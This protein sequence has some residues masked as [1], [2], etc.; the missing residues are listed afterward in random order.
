[1]ESELTRRRFV[2]VAGA[3]VVSLSLLQ[4]RCG[5]VEEGATE[6]APAASPAGDGCRVAP[7]YA[8]WQDVYRKQWTWDKVV[9]GAHHVINCV[10]QCSFNVFVQDG[11][12]WRE[13]QNTIMAATNSNYP[14]FNPR[15]CH[16]G[17]C[18]S[19]LMYGPTRIQHPLKRAGARI[20]PLEAH[21]LGR[22]PDRDR[23]QDGSTSATG[24]SGV[25]IYDSGT[26]NAG[27][28]SEGAERR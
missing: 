24:R 23:R 21:Q 3:G 12:V 18:T 8:G 19:N 28:G 9:K 22:G 15:G 20:G 13:E 1:M 25:V 11:V 2:Q 26:A 6:S 10:S 5:G 27:Y 7:V 14:D 17:V 4:L 16:K